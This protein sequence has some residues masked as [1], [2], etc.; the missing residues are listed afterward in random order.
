VCTLQRIAGAAVAV[1]VVFSSGSRGSGGG[2]D[3]VSDGGWWRV[4]I[5]ELPLSNAMFCAG[6]RMFTKRFGPSS[7]L[8]QTP[9]FC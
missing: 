7:D 6:W 9:I 8:L 4:G 2:N 3:G 1:A 5:G